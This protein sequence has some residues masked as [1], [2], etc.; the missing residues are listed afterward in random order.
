MMLKSL[1]LSGGVAAV[2]NRM[3][4]AIR[5]AAMGLAA[6]IFLAFFALLATGFLTAAA[7]LYLSAELGAIRACLIMAGVFLCLGVFAWLI[8]KLMAPRSRPKDSNS[9]PTAEG[10][11]EDLSRNVAS[12]G[13][14]AL[15][16]LGV[17]GYVLGR[18]VRDKK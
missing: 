4:D 13:I 2:R 7:V 1:L 16:M 8:I 10:L 18:L 5:G 15:V 6:N 3:A 14:P 12:G 17:A 11:V 9:L